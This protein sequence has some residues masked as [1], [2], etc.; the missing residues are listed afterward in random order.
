MDKHRETLLER[1]RPFGCPFTVIQSLTEDEIKAL[2]KFKDETC[3]AL[4]KLYKVMPAEKADPILAKAL[5]GI[6]D[7][8]KNDGG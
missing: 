2:H 3:D 1:L 5:Q 4:Q 7:D 6:L 8:Y